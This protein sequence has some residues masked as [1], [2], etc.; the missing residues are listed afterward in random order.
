[1][2][3]S[4]KNAYRAARVTPTKNEK[5]VATVGAVTVAGAVVSKVIIATGVGVA[6]TACANGLLVGGAAMV[7]VPMGKACVRGFMEGYRAERARVASI[8]DVPVSGESAS[9]DV[10][11]EI[12][13]G[14][15]HGT[16]CHVSL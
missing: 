5:V 6:G 11:A 4:F 1:M 9:S 15:D 2:F 13:D 14:A 10:P 8:S 7:V 3:E 12:I 16:W